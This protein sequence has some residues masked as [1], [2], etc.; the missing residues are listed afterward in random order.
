MTLGQQLAVALE[1]EIG[2]V[3]AIAHASRIA[4]AEVLVEAPSAPLWREVASCLIRRQ[5]GR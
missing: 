4:A 1:R 3:P 5:E 2:L